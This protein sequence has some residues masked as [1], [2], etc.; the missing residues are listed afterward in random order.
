MTFVDQR[1]LGRERQGFADGRVAARTEA[2]AR[3]SIA[4]VGGQGAGEL[5]GG[6]TRARDQS[7]GR[8]SVKPRE[9]R[10]WGGSF[11]LRAAQNGSRRTCRNPGWASAW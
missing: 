7:H 9:L 5:A 8:A 6:A 11:E 10:S 1:M 2:G 4:A 3:R